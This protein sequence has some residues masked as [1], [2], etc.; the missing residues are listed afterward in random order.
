MMDRFSALIRSRFA[1]QGKIA[2]MT[3]EGRL[4]GAI[5][6]LLPFAMFLLLLKLNPP[7]AL[8]LFD[9]Q[10]LVVFTLVSMTLGMIWIRRIVNFDF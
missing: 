7:Y 9:H 10:L 5:L 1:L 3:A 4:Q 6:L 8:Q 2:A